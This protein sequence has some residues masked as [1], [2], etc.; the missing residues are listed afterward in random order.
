EQ[1]I[2]RQR[3]VGGGDALSADHRL[4]SAAVIAVGEAQQA[5]LGDDELI[6]DRRRG[7]AVHCTLLGDLLCVRQ[8]HVGARYGRVV[9]HGERVVVDIQR[10][11]PARRVPVEARAAGG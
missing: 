1:E 9:V 4:I 2:R 5:L 7:S 10:G 11:R 3:A 8:L 6:E